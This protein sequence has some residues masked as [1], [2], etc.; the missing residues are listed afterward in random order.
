MSLFLDVLTPGE[1]LARS[2]VL[3]VALVVIAAAV[4]VAIVVRR[5]RKK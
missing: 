2:G 1:A 4:A 3:P 5:R